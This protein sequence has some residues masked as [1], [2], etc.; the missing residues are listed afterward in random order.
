MDLVPYLSGLQETVG[1][2]KTVVIAMG[3]QTASI[4]CQ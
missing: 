3:T 4:L 1:D 2:M